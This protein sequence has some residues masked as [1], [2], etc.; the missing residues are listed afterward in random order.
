MKARVEL[1]IMMK[2]HKKQ[3]PITPGWVDVLITWLEFV[4]ILGT[5]LAGIYGLVTWVF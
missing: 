2:K 5:I 1:P 3:R 4:G